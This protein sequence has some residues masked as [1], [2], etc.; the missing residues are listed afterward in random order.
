[1]ATDE[2]TKDTMEEEVLNLTEEED[3]KELAEALSELIEQLADDEN[4]RMFSDLSQEEIRHIS[5]LKSMNDTIIDEF[6]NEFE[7]LQV[8][9]RRKGRQELIDIAES[10]GSL[11]S[12][13]EDESRLDRLRGVL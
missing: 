8:S 6:L 10:V 4:I 11:A 13:E 1:M 9:Y 7:A 2:K 12:Q 3:G 5:V